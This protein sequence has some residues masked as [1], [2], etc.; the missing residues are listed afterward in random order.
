MF[1]ASFLTAIAHAAEL[2]S[3]TGSVLLEITGDIKLQNTTTTNVD[4]VAQPA[5]A[6]DIAMLESLPTETIRTKTEWTTGVTEFTGVR[7]DVL[8]N[9]LGASSQHLFLQALDEYSVEVV[10]GQFDS[11]PIIIAYKLN[12]EY[13]SVRELGPLWVMFP[14]D[15]HPEL[16]SEQ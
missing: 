7:V 11:F 16:N 6:F 1:S 2:G 3:P 13:M 8:L 14:F 12:G 4:G 9:H 5:A 15:D 10:D